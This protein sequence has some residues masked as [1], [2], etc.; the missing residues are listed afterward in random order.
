MPSIHLEVE[1]K[2]VADETFE[3]PPLTD[4]VRGL[5]EE[6]DLSTGIVP[7][8]EGE[9]A[10]QRLT[11]TY[12]DTADF[13][14]AAAGLTLRRRTGGED[15]G[16]HLKVPAGADARSEVRLPLGRSAR[17][18][19][20][21]LQRMV[22]VP[23]GGAALQP[24]AEIVTERTV[25]RLVDPTGQVLAE[26]ADDRVSAR[27]LLPLNGSGEAAGAAVSWRE[28]EVELVGGDTDLIDRVD[29]R[30]RA[31]GLRP[32]GAASKL[33]H[34]LGAGTGSGKRRRSP[35]QTHRVTAKTRAGEVVLA[36]LREQ[37]AQIRAQDLPVRLDAPDA[38]HKMRVATRRLRS[39][40]T[41]FKP[42]FADE[43]VRPLR[44]ELKWLAGELGAA[45]D[46]EVMRDR[47]ADAVR[48]DDTGVEHG[49]AATIANQELGDAYRGAHDRVLA[50]LDGERYHQ[51]VAALDDLVTAPPFTKRATAPAGKTLPKLVARSF[52]AVR[53]LVEDAT[54][55]PKGAE[56]EELLHDA[57][58]AAKATRYAAE[59]VDRVFGKDATAFAEAM[60]AVQEAL[61]EHQDSALTRQRLQELA[62][63]TSS[64]QAAFLYGRLH[65]LEEARDEQSQQHFGDAWRAA[66]RKSLHRW[67]R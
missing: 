60:E 37:A 11:A 67:L 8:A 30:L 42:L 21:A 56:R 18:V 35:K 66:G 44:G 45:R 61:G 26:V 50:E 15:A 65:A 23:S 24:V 43:V 27:R 17:T 36:H 59:S 16:W 14:L 38:V 63:R 22:R 4:L 5:N 19:P 12:F 47:V 55:R 54:G 29:T 1:K 32:A 62:L 28:I 51:L 34:L 64:P 9:S 48:G 20:A 13:R 31:G 10:R 33:A 58:K 39:A 2:Y 40:L 3:L 41:T 57:R 6:A 49:P 53:H 7:L 25:R 52:A 46:A